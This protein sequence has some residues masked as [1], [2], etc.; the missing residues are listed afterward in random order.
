MFLTILSIP[1][2][3]RFPNRSELEIGDLV[4]IEIYFHGKS[5]IEQGKISGFLTNAD[6]HPRGIKVSVDSG[7]Q[8]RVRKKIE[9]VTTVDGVSEEPET[10]D[11]EEFDEEPN[12]DSLKQETPEVEFKQTFA[13]DVE[14][15]EL[16]E[17]G[18]IEDADGRKKEAKKNKDRINKMVSKAAAAFANSSGGIIK[19]GFTDDG[20]ISAY[21]KKDKELYGDNWDKYTNA[22]TQSIMN[23]TDDEIFAS[24][25]KIKNKPGKEDYLE[26]E[27]PNR[28]ENGPP[29]FIDEQ[30]EFYIRTKSAARSQIV[31]DPA[32]IMSYCRK[33]FPK[34]N[35]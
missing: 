11:I 12:R 6:S 34:W 28:D 10:I 2:I 27:I 30:R 21:F 3:M 20:K 24:Q 4:E 31:K 19:I 14:E 7:S 35:P 23:F 32:K 17:A 16:R 9:Q 26:L 5:N 13:F 22:V 8:G 25:I 33:R 18:K 15:Y 29:I 1:T